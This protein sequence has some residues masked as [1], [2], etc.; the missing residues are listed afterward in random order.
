MKYTREQY[1]SLINNSILFNIDKE[2]DFALFKTEKFALI[3]LLTDYYRLYIYPNKTLDEYSMPLLETANDC[4]K[5][6]DRNKGEFLHLFNSLMKRNVGIAR[7]KE[8]IDRQRGGL[9]IS[10]DDSK[11]I[12][13]ILA[14]ANSK[15]ADIYDINAQEHIAAYLKISI[16]EVTELILINQSAIAVSSTV[17]NEDGDNIELYNT[18]TSKDASPEEIATQADTLRY[19]AKT[20]D[21]VFQAQQDRPV[22]KKVLS[23]MLTIKFIEGLDGDMDKLA[24]VM[25]G[26]SYANKEIIQAYIISKKIPTARFVA[27]QCNVAEQSVSRTY[28]NFIN[29]VKKYC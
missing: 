24:E 27:E 12:R 18:Q 13:K 6:Y 7:A 14:Y 15:G 23:M 3:T 28:T 29:K 10:K 11:R 22:S 8:T 1:E 5:Y 25:K 20:I 2:K 9:T 17:T 26:I 4:I 21:K 19:T 16:D